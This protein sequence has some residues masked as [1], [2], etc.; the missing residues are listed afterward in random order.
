VGLPYTPPTNLRETI[1]IVPSP[2]ASHPRT[3]KT[4]IQIATAQHSAAQATAIQS[5][6]LS[7]FIAMQFVPRQ[8]ASS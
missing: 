5:K 7:R 8:L 2:T 3:I 4:T 1:R 6:T